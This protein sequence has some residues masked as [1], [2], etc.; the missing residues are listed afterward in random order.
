MGGERAVELDEWRLFRDLRR[1]GAGEGE[2]M[3]EGEGVG[4]GGGAGFLEDGEEV[5]ADRQGDT[6]FGGLVVIGT[7]AR[8]DELSA[9]SVEVGIAGDAVGV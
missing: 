5:A 7:V 9:A 8:E 3:A 1:I 2:G 6:C 4:G